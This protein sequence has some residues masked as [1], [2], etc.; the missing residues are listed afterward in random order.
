[1]TPTENWATYRGCADSKLSQ[2]FHGRLT[3]PFAVRALMQE[4]ALSA[5]LDP[6]GLSFIHAVR[7][8]RRKLNA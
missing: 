7:F 2:E 6:D 3:A 4:A 1:L 5:G 8:R